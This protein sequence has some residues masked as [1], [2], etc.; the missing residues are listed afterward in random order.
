MPHTA[1]RPLATIRKVLA[2]DAASCL[3]MGLAMCLASA[4]LS[5]VFALPQPLVWWAGAVLFPCAALML[6]A[7]WPRTT[8]V[9]LVWLVVVGNAAWAGA[10]VLTVAVFAPSGIGTLFVLGQAAAVAVLAWLEYRSLP[11][12][13]AQ[14]VARTAHA[15]ATSAME[16]SD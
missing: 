9:A 1:I 8:P 4:A 10:S 14:V 15:R 16:P 2:F 13:R 11:R 3:A 5:R 7:A 12:G 6:L